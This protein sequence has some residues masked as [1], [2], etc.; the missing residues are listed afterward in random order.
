[1]SNWRVWAL[2]RAKATDNPYIFETKKRTWLKFFHDRELLFFQSAWSIP[3][4]N[5]AVLM[6][7]LS[8]VDLIF[9]L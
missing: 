6:G 9:F 5:I 7:R 8:T 4:Q 3:I 1:M 2:L